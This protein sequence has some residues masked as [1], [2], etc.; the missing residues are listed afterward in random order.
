MYKSP[1]L[2][3]DNEQELVIS[4]HC[5]AME[6]NDSTTNEFS[7]IKNR[8]YAEKVFNRIVYAEPPWLSVALESQRLFNLRGSHIGEIQD[9]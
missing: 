9:H 7:L 3:E 2:E 8:D 4:W 5:L 1:T 6:A